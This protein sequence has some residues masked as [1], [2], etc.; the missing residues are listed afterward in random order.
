MQ[1]VSN[2]DN[3]HEMSNLF[4][5]KNKKHIVN[6]LS[7]EFAQR[8]VKVNTKNSENQYIQQ[9]CLLIMFDSMLDFTQLLVNINK[10]VT[11]SHVCSTSS[12]ICY[13]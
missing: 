7:A 2:G 4:S 9:L 3:L 8:V 6:L 13:E 11:K 10:L 5:G 12:D 1:I